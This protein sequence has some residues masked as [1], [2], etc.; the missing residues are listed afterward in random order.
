MMSN[1]IAAPEIMA[2][3]ATDLATIGSDLRAAHTAAATQTTG[4]L[5]AAEDE[6]SAAI[7]A[8]F[9]THG[10][11]FQAVGA[12]AAA[13]HAQFVQALHADAGAYASTEAANAAMIFRPRSP[14]PNIAVSVGGHTLEFGT[15]TASSDPGSLAIAVGTNSSAE[16]G[17]FLAGQR[18]T[19]IA[20]GAHSTADALYGNRSVAFVLGTGSHAF[21]GPGGLHPASVLSTDCTA[22]VLGN[23]SSADASFGNH[24]IAAALG[25]DLS[26]TAVGGNATNIV[27][28]FGTAEAQ[29]VHT[30]G[31]IFAAPPITPVPA[32]L[33]PTFSGT[34]SLLTK[35]ENA[36]VLQALK[37]FF[38]LP[39]VDHQLVN[40]NSPLMTL[41][42]DAPNIPGLKLLLGNSPPTFLPL[43][44]GETVQ[45]TGYQGMPVVQ[46]TPAHPDG[47]Y[48][49]AIHGGAGILP[50]LIFHWIDYSMMA[51]QTG[52]T[53]EVPLYP[54]VQQGGTAGVIIPKMAGLI[55]SEITAH[56]AS[57]VSVLGDSA[58]GT[59]GLSSV[60]YLVA[61]NETVPGAMVL[62]SPVVDLTFSN[63]A[64]G[65]INSWLPPTST[66]KQ[67]GQSWVGG[68]PVTDYEVSPL[69]GSLQG[70]PPTTIYAG[71]QDI[72][73]P[74][75]AILQQNAV[76]QGAPISFVL[77]NG[78][79]H[80]WIPITPD[81]LHY[82]PQIDRELGI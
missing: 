64:I 12:Q 71:S 63:P 77:A 27:T 44:L 54:L 82:W 33:N 56:G 41:F 58:G 30:L 68:L 48:V 53:I 25:H 39:P 38:N 55:E 2:T 51:F 21:A 7:V 20:V 52:A 72:A 22:V 80:D 15:A 70:L 74:D 35:I 32:T 18:D 59:I 17:S 78:E 5:A 81:G 37:I 1:L 49:V 50:P 67:I 75:L 45:Q 57:H 29:A 23:G 19:A 34:P 13:F 47:D 36:T 24:N 61:H 3:A 40:L 79:T 73:A 66:L 26:A 11:G 14:L 31:N 76:T 62:L 42:A 60:E 43:L 16:A 9:S 4:V 6:V 8:L 46:I 28:P 65:S 10:Q 69:Y